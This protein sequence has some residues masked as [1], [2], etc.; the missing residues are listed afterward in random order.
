MKWPSACRRF[1]KKIQRKLQVNIAW[2]IFAIVSRTSRA[3]HSPGV[4]TKSALADGLNE[5][6]EW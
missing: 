4:F 1:G 5:L 3:P 2:A 6:L